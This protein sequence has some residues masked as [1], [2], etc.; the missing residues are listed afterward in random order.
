MSTKM[1]ILHALH[2]SDTARI[3]FT[4]PASAGGIVINAQTFRRVA[5]AIQNGT[6][7]LKVSTT[8]PPGVGAQYT[9]WD[10]TIET[11][12][13]IGRVEEGLLLHECTHA[14]FDIASTAITA[15]HD[16]AAAYVVDALY[17]RMTGL[18]RP[19]WNAEPHATARQVAAGVLHQYAVGTHHAPPV[20]APTWAALLTAIRTHPVYVTGPAGT[21]GSYLHN[22]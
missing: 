3:R 7:K 19:R 18:T 1:R 13:V 8:F 6:I 15:L 14:S 9:P 4:L 20:D 22:G 17:F 16:E 11:P 10:N 5:L 12:P 2:S 21:G